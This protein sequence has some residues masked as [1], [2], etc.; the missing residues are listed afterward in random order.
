[1][2]A[3]VGLHSVMDIGTRGLSSNRIEIVLWPSPMPG[4][5]YAT[6]RSMSIW[7]VVGTLEMNPL[8]TAFTDSATW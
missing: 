3:T 4:A 6:I 5:D 8:R 2:I 7:P 1:M